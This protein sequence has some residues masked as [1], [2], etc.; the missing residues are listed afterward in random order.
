MI[1][2]IFQKAAI[3]KYIILHKIKTTINYISDI[4]VGV[5]WVVKLSFSANR[6]F[7]TYIKT[8]TPF[9][10]FIKGLIK[11][12]LKLPS[13]VTAASA[14]KFCALFMI[15]VWK[16]NWKS[17]PSTPAALWKPMPILPSMIRFTAVSA[18][19][20]LMTRNTSLLTAARFP[21]SLP[22]IRPNCHG[23]N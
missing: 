19:M 14:V 16:T 22:V 4:I 11:W 10:Y 7:S 21:F 20:F 15:M 6:P 23:A 17:L 8:E 12:A 13:M 18:L 3:E 2:I 1:Y 9:S 5:I